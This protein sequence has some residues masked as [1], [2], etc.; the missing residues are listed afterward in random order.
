MCFRWAIWTSRGSSRQASRWAL[1]TAWWCRVTSCDPVSTTSA[2]SQ[3][4]STRRWP[5]PTISPSTT[6]P[7]SSSNS[8]SSN[9]NSSNNP[10]PTTL[11]NSSSSSSNNNSSSKCKTPADTETCS[12][13]VDNSS[14]RSS[15][16][17]N[18]AWEDQC[19]PP[20]AALVSR[21]LLAIIMTV[22]NSFTRLICFLP[23]SGR[24]MCWMACSSICSW[25][26][27]AN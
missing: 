1:R 15:S 2:A 7:S 3:A 13:G 25:A 27:R 5:R 6:H 19:A 26:L 11:C 21:L 22:I 4:P 10:S 24:W 14:S 16:N 20:R 23:P 17:S 9:S 8:S 12:A 18:K